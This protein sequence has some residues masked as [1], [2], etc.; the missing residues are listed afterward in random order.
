MVLY[1]QSDRLTSLSVFLLTIHAPIHSWSQVV[2]LVIHLSVHQTTTKRT[3]RAVWFVQQR[4]LT[5]IDSGH[6]RL[7]LRGLGRHGLVV[8]QIVDVLLQVVLL[9][10]GGQ[11]CTRTHTRFDTS[12][13]GCGVGDSCFCQ[14]VALAS[15]N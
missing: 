2:T 6:F 9:F 1:A 13:P 12:A 3:R 8:K 11:F 10:I 4:L 7:L 14:S 15:G 5:F